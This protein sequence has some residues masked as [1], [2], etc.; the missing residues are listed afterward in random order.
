MKSL[1]GLCMIIT[2]ENIN[3]Y[4]YHSILNIN[5]N[6]TTELSFIPDDI[7][8]LFA[9]NNPNIVI[10]ADIPKLC[11]YIDIRNCELTEL[12]FNC[13][14][15]PECVIEVDGNNFSEEYL[16]WLK[17]KYP[18]LKEHNSVGDC[19]KIDYDISSLYPQLHSPFKLTTSV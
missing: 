8:I 15:H 9:Q 5:S 19:F 4:Q 16:D 17:L 10:T 13:E 18:N 6:K 2:N 11:V 7:T 3:K 1:R 12:P 14:L